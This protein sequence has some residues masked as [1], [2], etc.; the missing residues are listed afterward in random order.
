[1]KLENQIKELENKIKNTY[2]Q[3]TTTEEAEKLAAE[4]LHAQMLISAELATVDLDARMKKSG[5]KAVKAAVYIEACSKS[6]KKPTES[7]L[8]HT[9]S[10][11]EAVQVEQDKLDIAEVDR[12]NLTRYYNIFRDGHIYYRGI[13][14]GSFNVG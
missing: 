9:I 1:M 4:F 14:K 2:T 5:V 11:N 10:L 12:D 6:D 13:A 8:E 7:A 3:G